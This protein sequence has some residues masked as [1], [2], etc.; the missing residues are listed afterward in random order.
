MPDDREIRLSGIFCFI[1][2]D[3][4]VRL[5]DIGMIWEGSV[6]EAMAINK[7]KSAT[8]PK[9]SF[10]DWKDEAVR[11]LKG[12]PFKQLVTQTFEGIDLYPLYTAEHLHRTINY[13]DVIS[14][15]RHNGNW[16]IAQKT[17]SKT[18][19]DFLHK[20]K[21]QLN[22]GN[23]MVV[24]DGSLTPY[25]WSS[26][27]LKEL[28]NLIKKHPFYFT[29]ANPNDEITRVFSNM[30]DAEKDEL[31][32]FVIGLSIPSAKNV[33]STSHIHHEGGTAVHELAFALVELSKIAANQANFTSKVAVQFSIDTNF[34]MEIG[35]LRAFRILWKA[36][37]KAYDAEQLPISIIAETSLRSYSKLDLNVNL[38][39]AGNA[40]F[41]AVLGGADIITVH[42]HDILT[43]TTSVSQRIAQN[44][45]LVI[46]EETMVSKF[47]DPSAG[48]YYIETLTAEL[49]HQAW[50]LFLALTDLESNEQSDHLMSLAKEVQSSRSQSIAMRK[51]SLIGTN[52]YANPVDE[53]SSNVM[54]E[55]VQRLAIP[56]EQLREHFSNQPLKTAV[57]SFGTLRDVKP[58]A[59]FVQGFLQAGGLNPDM[60]PVFTS[61][62]HAWHWVKSNGIDYVVIAA[63]DEDTVKYVPS[64]LQLK[65]AQTIIDVA[66]KFSEVGQWQELGLNGTIFAG[67]NLIEKM[68]QL[69]DILKE[70][71]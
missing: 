21:E 54:E 34:F 46:R 29:I 38:L 17:N 56:F 13:S 6:S 20:A 26:E 48:S 10:D 50:E 62:E 69:I 30:T 27:E 42:P 14:N 43:G 66:G 59:D 32:G 4:S 9:A 1:V 67:Q 51:V 25:S 58:R 8:F 37:S 24:Y 23:D 52:K 55:P 22:I 57:V 63:K 2:S 12:K 35:K 40:T 44:V 33:V 16:L 18:A 47:S 64:F 11:T 45:Q 61:A 3:C 68:Q 70:E 39:R 15:A 28:S 41:S 7:M 36:F 53:V 19:E 71:E 31:Q 49:V 65:D 5:D 60:S